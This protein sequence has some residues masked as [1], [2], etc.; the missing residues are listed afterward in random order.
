MKSKAYMAIMSH[1]SDAQQLIDSSTKEGD[2]ARQYIYLAKMIL[3]KYKD[4][5]KQEVEWSELDKLWIEC[6]E[7]FGNGQLPHLK[8]GGLCGLNKM[9]L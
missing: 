6:K 9:K 7:R 1:L 3:R 2:T 4:D 5:I 8:E